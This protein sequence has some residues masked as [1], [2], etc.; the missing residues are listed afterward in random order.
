M[1]RV[2]IEVPVDFASDH[3]QLV[4]QSL[5]QVDGGPPGSFFVRDGAGQQRVAEVEVFYYRY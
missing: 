1:V 2:V 3:C 4:P 5:T